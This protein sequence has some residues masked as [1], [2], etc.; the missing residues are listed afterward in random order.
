MHGEYGSHLFIN[1]LHFFPYL[2][3]VTKGHKFGPGRVKIEPTLLGCRIN[4][5]VVVKPH[6]TFCDRNFFRGKT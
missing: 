3:F 2:V 6:P 1:L 5:R 4:P